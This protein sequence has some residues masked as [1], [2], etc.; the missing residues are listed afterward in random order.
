MMPTSLSEKGAEHGISQ[1]AADHLLQADAQ[2]AADAVRTHVK[3]PLGQE[4]FDALISFVFNVGAGNFESS[5]LL[6][7]LNQH[8]YGAVPG[9]LMQW[10]HA[11]GQVLPG[12]VARRKAEGQLFETEKYP[13]L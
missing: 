5:T 11:G 1:K 7:E 2:I 3:V 6:K 9:Q 13:K 4:R 12:L 8:H 10:T